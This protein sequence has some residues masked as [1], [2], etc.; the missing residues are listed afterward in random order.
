MMLPS[1]PH[2]APLDGNET[3]AANTASH[4]FEYE[5][6]RVRVALDPA[7]TKGMVSGHADL[8]DRAIFKCR[9]ALTGSHHDGASAIKA[10]ARRACALIDERQRRPGNES[11]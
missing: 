8:Y 4:E 9:L 7:R 6:W 3:S 11:S 10:L 1:G 5:G 2:E